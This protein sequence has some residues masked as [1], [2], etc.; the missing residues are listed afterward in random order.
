MLEKEIREI[1]NLEKTGGID[2]EIENLQIQKRGLEK[3]RKEKED[4]KKKLKKEFRSLQGLV[5][6]ARRQPLICPGK[7][8]KMGRMDCSW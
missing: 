6:T 4:E 5:P 8:K 2:T 3:Q 7:L 1:E